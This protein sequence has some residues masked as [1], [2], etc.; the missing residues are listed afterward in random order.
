MFIFKLYYDFIKWLIV[1]LRYK[2]VSQVGNDIQVSCDNTL[3]GNSRATVQQ[4]CQRKSKF[5]IYFGIQKDDMIA[6]PVNTM[7]GR[8]FYHQDTVFCKSYSH[9]S[10]Q[11]VFKGLNHVRKHVQQ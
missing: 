8:G 11:L 6:L 4:N 2:N 3:V 7:S 9:N 1:D 10:I 5:R